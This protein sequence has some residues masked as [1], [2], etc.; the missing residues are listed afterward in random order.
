MQALKPQE[1]ER[2]PDRTTTASSIDS[3][4]VVAR[5]SVNFYITSHKGAITLTE[6][7]SGVPVGRTGI[8]SV[9]T[10]LEEDV[11][12]KLESFGI[13]VHDHNPCLDTPEVCL[14]DSL[15]T[16]RLDALI[17]SSNTTY[18]YD[19]LVIHC[20]YG[21]SRSVFSVVYCLLHRHHHLNSSSDWTGLSPIL[22]LE[23]ILRSVQAARPCVAINSGFLAQLYLLD[24]VLRERVA[25]AAA[26]IA[27][28]DDDVG[29]DADVGGGRVYCRA[30][31]TELALPAYTA[32]MQA[33]SSSSSSSQ[34]QQAQV[35]FTGRA[36]DPRLLTDPLHSQMQAFIHT[37]ADPFWRHFIPHHVGAAMAAAAKKRKRD[38]RDKHSKHGGE[39]DDDEETTGLLPGVVLTP[40]LQTKRWAF[41]PIGPSTGKCDGRVSCANIRCGVVLGVY[42]QLSVCCNYVLI[43]AVALDKASVEVK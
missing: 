1:A 36:M 17:C 6:G 20:V 42:R 5:G 21:Q 19:N 2:E 15:L 31:H 4:S 9:G 35:L 37:H 38:Q 27:S 34:P 16:R 7:A 25:A 30:C 32:P 33:S 13:D 23:D 40:V 39:G 18:A 28:D 43:D 10:K 29:D 26:G 41:V 22:R 14:L 12:A 11:I 8:L 3:V 24:F